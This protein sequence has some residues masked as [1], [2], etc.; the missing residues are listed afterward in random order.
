[1]NLI[2]DREVQRIRDKKDNMRSILVDHQK[3]LSNMKSD[4]NAYKTMGAAAFGYTGQSMRA[5]T[6]FY[7]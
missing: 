7:P 5:S 6:N 4:I 2:F 3:W 1:M